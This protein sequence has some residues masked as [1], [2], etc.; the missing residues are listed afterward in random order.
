MKTLKL[1]TIFGDRLN[2]NGDQANLFILQQRL[3]WAGYSSE[4]LSVSSESELNS[5]NADILLLGH[6]SLAA[7]QICLSEW[8]NLGKAFTDFSASK[9]ALAVSSGAD[10]VLRDAAIDLV[11]MPDNISEF[12]EERFIETALLGYKNTYTRDNQTTQLNGAVL[13]WLHGPVLAK[14]PKLA[15]W[16]ISALLGVAETPNLTNE[17][18]RKIDEIVAGVWQLEK[19]QN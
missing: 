9:P 7:W 4:I 8:P 12:C 19:P 11:L 3:K 5:A 13:T 6:G 1:A 10:Q 16:F 17:N 14:N 18:T 2:L 15:D